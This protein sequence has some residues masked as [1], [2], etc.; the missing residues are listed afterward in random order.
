M[1]KQAYETIAAGLQDALAY[2]KGDASRVT[3]V[4]RAVPPVAALDVKAIRERQGMSQREFSA[5]YSIPLMTLTKWEQ[6]INSPTGPARL[7]L[8]VIDQHPKVVRKVAKGVQ[9]A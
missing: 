7:L 2:A 8:H 1:S 3:R 6:G 5:L 9:A 4:H